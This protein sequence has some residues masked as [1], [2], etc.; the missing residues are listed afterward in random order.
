MRAVVTGF[1]HNSDSQIEPYVSLCVLHP[2]WKHSHMI[3]TCSPVWWSCFCSQTRTQTILWKGLY[4][5]S[6]E[7]RS[8]VGIT[9][10]RASVCRV[11]LEWRK[12]SETVK[13]RSIKVFF[14]CNIKRI[15]LKFQRRLNL[16]AVFTV[17]KVQTILPQRNHQKNLLTYSM[18]AG[19]ELTW[20]GGL[21]FVF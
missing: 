14:F 18:R 21:A 6:P 11:Q 1:C 15:S 3:F 2:L 19:G 9:S 10:G 7:T 4:D 8:S 12:T 20:E 13:F 16:D 5:V 17:S